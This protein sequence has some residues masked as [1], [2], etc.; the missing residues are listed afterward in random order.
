MRLSAS[1]VNASM[2]DILD[3]ISAS[4]SVPRDRV[5]LVSVTEEGAFTTGPHAGDPSTAV[6]FAVTS[7]LTSL[8]TPDDTRE[9]HSFLESDQLLT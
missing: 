9:A 3:A 8:L 5:Q 1:D 2:S 6:A 4:A 7:S